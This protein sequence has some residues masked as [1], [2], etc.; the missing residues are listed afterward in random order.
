MVVVVVMVVTNIS[1]TQRLSLLECA[2]EGERVREGK[3]LRG[4][5]TLEDGA[6]TVALETALLLLLLELLGVGL[7]RAVGGAIAV[8]VGNVRGSPLLVVVRV[9]AAPDLDL[10]AGGEVA[11][12]DVEAVVLGQGRPDRVDVLV[13]LALDGRKVELL[14]VRLG[15]D[16]DPVLEEVAVVVVAVRDVDAVVTSGLASGLPGVDL[17]G[18]VLG[19]VGVGDT[20]AVSALGE[21]EAGTVLDVRDGETEVLGLDGG[22]VEGSRL[23]N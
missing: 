10:G 20:V 2:R 6:A 1:K 22:D 15:V 5:A 9:D 21:L 13:L 19:V 11:V 18:A 12:L 17:E 8:R 3:P 16:A 23:Q 7:H 14:V 4:P